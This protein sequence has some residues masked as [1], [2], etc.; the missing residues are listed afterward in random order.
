[1][2]E[3]DDLAE[4]K[5][6]AAKAFKGVPYMSSQLSKFLMQSNPAAV[7][8]EGIKLIA[9]LIELDSCLIH[10]MELNHQDKSLSEIAKEI[11]PSFPDIALLTPDGF[12]VDFK[13]KALSVLEVFVRVKDD[14]FSRKW[15]L[16][17]L[18]YDSVKPTFEKETGW[19]LRVFVDGRRDYRNSVIEDYLITELRYKLEKFS[20]YYNLIDSSVQ[21]IEY[22]RLLDSL[23]GHGQDLGLQLLTMTETA[24]KASLTSLFEE[25]GADNL[26]LEGVKEYLTDIQMTAV[27]KV[28]SDSES[29]NFKHASAEAIYEEYATAYLSSFTYSGPSISMLRYLCRMAERFWDIKDMSYVGSLPILNKLKSK[30][31]VNTK[32]NN[33]IILDILRMIDISTAYQ[34]GEIKKEFVRFNFTGGLLKSVGDR[35]VCPKILLQERNL[36]NKCKR[37]DKG[38]K[39]LLL[40]DEVE[41][42]K[43]VLE[44]LNLLLSK[45]TE[46]NLKKYLEEVFKEVLDLIPKQTKVNVRYDPDHEPK[47]ISLIEEDELIMTLLTTKDDLKLNVSTEE[48]VKNLCTLKEGIHKLSDFMFKM[49]NIPYTC[50]SKICLSLVNSIKTRS[51]PKIKTPD[52]TKSTEYVEPRECFVQ[53]IWL[54][55]NLAYLSTGENSK[56]YTIVDDECSVSFGAKPT[57]F[58][59]PVFSQSV[60]QLLEFALISLV[61]DLFMVEG[62]EREGELDQLQSLI[63]LLLVLI[64]CSMSKRVQILLQNIRYLAMAQVNGFFMKKLITKL[65]EPLKSR[66]EKLIFLVLLCI[67][68]KLQNKLNKNG[69]K[70]AYFKF[71]LNISYLCHYI[72]KETPDRKTDIVKCFEKYLEPKIEFSKLVNQKPISN[73]DGPSERQKK[74][75]AELSFFFSKN[76]Q[77]SSRPGIDAKLLKCLFFMFNSGQIEG[78][79]RTLKRNP[80]YPTI[81]PTVLDLASNKSSVVRVADK[82][83]YNYETVLSASLL[84][85]YEKMNNSVFHSDKKRL[86]I[87]KKVEELLKGSMEAGSLGDVEEEKF[88][89][90]LKKEYKIAESEKSTKPGQ[91]KLTP[92]NNDLLNSTSFT[93]TKKFWVDNGLTLPEANFIQHELK[94]HEASEID[95]SIISECSLKAFC[96]RFKHSEFMFDKPKSET[97]IEDTLKNFTTHCYYEEDYKTCFVSL[98]VN[99]GANKIHGAYSYT[100]GPQNKYQQNVKNIRDRSRITERTSNSEALSKKL[101]MCE[102]QL[103]T[104]KNLIFYS[105]DRPSQYDVTGPGT[106][107]LYFGL[108]YKE[109]VGSNR[110]LYVGDINT[111]LYTR[112]IED[113]FETLTSNF[114]GSCLNDDRSFSMAL[115]DMKNWVVSDKCVY[116]M[117]HSKWGPH[118]SPAAFIALLGGLNLLQ[119][120]GTILGKEE[121]NT[122]LFW[123]LHKKVEVPYLCL[124]SYFES[125]INS[126]LKIMEEKGK[127]TPTFT[128]VRELLKD[129]KVPS[130]F[131]SVLDMGQGILH[132]ASDFYGLVTENFI[133]S[134]LKLMMGLNC[135][136]YTSS[137][138]EIM[139]IDLDAV[140]LENSHR[141]LCILEIHK[142]LSELLNKYV[143]PKSVLGSFCG[144]FKS[145][146]FIWS[147]E[148]PLI[149]KFTLASLHNLKCK[150]PEQLIDTLDTIMD[151]CCANGVPIYLINS[152]IKRMH[153]LLGYAGYVPSPF[154]SY[155]DTDST[156]WTNG[157]RSYRIQ[158]TVEINQEVSQ[159]F[160]HAARQLYH[161]LLSGFQFEEFIQ[162]ALQE[163]GKITNY[164]SNKYNLELKAKFNAWLSPTKIAPLRLILRSKLLKMTTVVEEIDA[165]PLVK[166][167]QNRLTKNFSSGAKQALSDSLRKS[168]FQSCV[169]S[170]FTGL[171]ESLGSKCVRGTEKR[172]FS[173]RWLYHKDCSC[174]PVNCCEHLTGDRL[175]FKRS[176]S[177]DILCMYLLSA[178]ENGPW[179]LG[180]V[181]LPVT[182]ASR[183][184]AQK[185]SSHSCCIYEKKAGLQDRASIHQVLY[186]LKRN[187]TEIFNKFIEPYLTERQV[188]QLSWQPRQKALDTCITIEL[189]L[190]FLKLLSRMMRYSKSTEY[191]ISKY[192]A[193]QAHTRRTDREPLQLGKPTPTMSMYLMRGEMALKSFFCPCL[194]SSSWIRNLDSYNEL[195]LSEASLDVFSVFGQLQHFIWK[196]AKKGYSGLMKIQDL[197]S[198]YTTF[199]YQM[200]ECLPSK[201]SENQ[202]RYLSSLYNSNLSFLDNFECFMEGEKLN[203]ILKIKFTES[204][205]ALKL[206]MN[207]QLIL[208][209]DAILIGFESKSKT[210]KLNVCDIFYMEVFTGNLSQTASGAMS[211]LQMVVDNNSQFI[212]SGEFMD[213]FLGLQKGTVQYVNVHLKRD[214]FRPSEIA[215]SVNY[216]ED[217]K[218]DFTPMIYADHLL[219]GIG[220]KIELGWVMSI[221]AGQRREMQMRSAQEN[222]DRYVDALIESTHCRALISMLTEDQFETIDKA[223]SAENRQRLGA[224]LN[225]DNRDFYSVGQRKIRFINSLNSFVTPNQGGKYSYRGTLCSL[226]SERHN[227]PD[228]IEVE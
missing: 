73:L 5:Y 29:E 211:L 26:S 226:F 157:S 207:T 47:P 222:P 74:L 139:M 123:H 105:S 221:E 80:N 36:L 78:F 137:D 202:V 163:E 228:A 165:P 194:L 34:R 3:S 87:F 168:A 195:A 45:N 128:Y 223:L 145:R 65:V 10:E 85:L 227:K 104:L 155:Y 218:E 166:V 117:D 188:S 75:L 156:D 167:L 82:E 9:R 181:S 37:W 14:Q 40:E 116:S 79:S 54:D 2:E 110:E 204:V 52:K 1:M 44:L 92:Q 197:V 42:F 206:W 22:D 102:L 43:P 49:G 90:M 7:F 172:C 25:V 60:L 96:D 70:V 217:K 146:F 95:L 138:D 129:G 31:V 169:A 8:V 46:E 67:M 171:C 21:D 12:K 20:K 121:V 144:E 98:I 133:H 208:N 68:D 178:I 59:S 86:P 111:K 6:L 88:I 175:L 107:H 48:G 16:D 147:E 186:S 182:A 225:K 159:E 203:L 136:S 32:K 38:C 50:V 71:M 190:S 185:T 100:S 17:R 180:E 62:D 57:R 135:R 214:S 66:L 115:E 215:V 189:N 19:Q 150:D 148:V 77:S 53:P 51:V 161:E 58:F 149:T 89:S 212:Y 99:M 140:D 174:E 192:D 213:C 184:V 112:L 124:E 152:C 35:L 30:N 187:H 151:Q 122:L 28:F 101:M 4:L 15:N 205:S 93:N 103:P 24:Y 160:R 108:S 83:E 162:S 113:Y 120:D 224:E 119:P 109:Q 219:L 125:Y 191:V 18:K 141:I 143:S 220:N 81:S 200:T 114:K 64:S 179:V 196:V 183:I 41:V 33:L 173:L 23:S 61:E 142:L 199:N 63:R 118:M 94:Y 170:G 11:C 91:M 39:S 56:T 72:T 126:E 177:D 158:R 106:D 201:E 153:K 216:T 176:V 55:V 27:S 164:A 130:N 132:N 154:H 13:E 97:L 84:N 127:Y 134:C 76:I 209:A 193:I 131:S 69:F 198:S 210:V